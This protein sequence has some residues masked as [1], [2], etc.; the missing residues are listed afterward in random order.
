MDYLTMFS[1]DNLALLSNWLEDTGELYI[2]VYVPHSSGG[3]LDYF[4]YSIDDLKSLIAQQNSSELLV[5]IFHHL[6][7]PLRGIADA[8]LLDV[9]RAYIP[10]GEWYSIVSLDHTFPSATVLLASGSSHE[11][12]ARDFADVSGN[13]IAIG[14]NPFDIRKEA[15]WFRTHPDEVFEVS[16]LRSNQY[17]I[18]KNRDY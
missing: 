3:S 11:Q 15:D 16:V 7:F 18:V 1:A 13:M 8:E 17:A 4:V 10:D 14:Q 9:A 12:M 6:Q 2:D 5:T